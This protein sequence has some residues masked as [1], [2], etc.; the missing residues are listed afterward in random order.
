MRQVNLQSYRERTAKKL[1]T[2]VELKERVTRDID[3]T[4]A[5]LETI[6]IQIAVERRERYAPIEMKKTKM[7]IV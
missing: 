1:D 3:R 6:D 4:A 2:L 7:E 5:L